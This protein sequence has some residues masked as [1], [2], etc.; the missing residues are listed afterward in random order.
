MQVN[1]QLEC[2]LDDNSSNYGDTGNLD[3][4]KTNRLV[5]VMD[6]DLAPDA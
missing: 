1:Q 5:V 6:K 4:R 3:K 2:N